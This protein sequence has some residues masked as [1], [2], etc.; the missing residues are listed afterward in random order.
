MKTLILIVL[1]TTSQFTLAASIT[2][3]EAD[4]MARNVYHEARGLKKRDWI[5]VARVLLARKSAYSTSKRFHARSSNLCD[6]AKS[7][8]YSS[9]LNKPIKEKKVYREIK[10]T[11]KGVSSGGHE[12]YFTSRKGK[13]FYK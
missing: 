6:L 1:L 5:R 2:S 12:L 13:M 9:R 11:L 10:D 3:A 8:E 4:C 7:K